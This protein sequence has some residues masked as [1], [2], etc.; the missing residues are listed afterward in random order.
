MGSPKLYLKVLD[1]QDQLL[2]QG[3]ETIKLLA[4]RQ[5][6]VRQAGFLMR[7]AADAHHDFLDDHLNRPGQIGIAL[8]QPNFR[9]S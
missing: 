2:K 8:R 6:E 7:R 4:D 3:A 9:A 1:F 5:A